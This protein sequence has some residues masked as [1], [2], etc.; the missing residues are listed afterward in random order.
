MTDML[1]REHGAY[2]QLLAPLVG[3]LIAFG[4]ST[5]AVLLAL[6]GCCAF[7]ANEPMLVLL[8]H[9]GKRALQRDGAKARV[10]LG[11]FAGGAAIAGVSGL[12]LAGPARVPAAIVAVPALLL[13]V[14]AWKRVIH[15]LAGELVA[16]VVLA[17]VSLPVAAASGARL[18]DALLLWAA[19]SFGF[20]YT[21]V[22][23]HRVIDRRRVP[24]SASDFV[25]AVCGLIGVVALAVASTRYEHARIAMPLALTATVLFAARPSPRR[26]RAIGI[27][28]VVAALGS[29]VLVQT[30]HQSA[31]P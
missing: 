5:A 17:G 16:V 6:A 14:L 7:A 10:W 15:T 30:V 29:L 25:A 21:I 22:C 11:V 18:A 1:P 24:I 19:W 27:V 12:V 8:G 2:A 9:R 23:V 28:L 26:L 13:V 3:T 20:A 31:S 4:A